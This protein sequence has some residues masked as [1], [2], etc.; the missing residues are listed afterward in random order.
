MREVGETPSDRPEAIQPQG[1]HGQAPE[2]GHDLDAVG[3][4]V[5]VRVF[6]ELGV[7]GPVPGVLDQPTVTHVTQQSFCAGKQTRVAPIA[8]LSKDVLTSLVG[9][10]A[11]ADALAT[12]GDHRGA[13]RPVLHYPHRSRHGPQRPG[14]VPAV[15]ALA[16]AGLQR[17]LPAVGQAILDHLKTL[18]AAVFHRDQEV[19]A[20]LFE[21]EK[22]GRFACNASACTSSPS[23]STRSSSWRS[24][25]ISPPASVA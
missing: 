14:D 15:F 18:V 3:L 25:A 21:V 22:K 1:V 10:L 2:R 20:T 6:L 11:I 7:A 8:A 13:A 12:H 17:C 23:S 5:A 9:W 19:G 16:L 4:A 24:A